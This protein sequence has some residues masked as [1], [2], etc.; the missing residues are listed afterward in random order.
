MQRQ[1]IHR[2]VHKDNNNNSNGGVIIIVVKCINTM[3]KYVC[4][5]SWMDKTFDFKPNEKQSLCK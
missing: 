4:Y 1:R 5:S 3:K 2:K